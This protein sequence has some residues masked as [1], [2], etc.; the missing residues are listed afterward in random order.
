[1]NKK[2]E[3]PIIEDNSTKKESEQIYGNRISGWI[4]KKI[5]NNI[6]N[7]FNNKNLVNDILNDIHLPKE[8]VSKITNIINDSKEEVITNIVKEFNLFLND[9]EIQ[10]LLKKVFSGIALKI[11]ATIT[12]IPSDKNSSK[13]S[14]D[15]KD[16]FFKQIK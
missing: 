14:V 7:V 2:V 13:V 16:K 3:E 15:I 1:M 8:I 5:K 9:L 12:I 11:D 10:K 6:S 4:K